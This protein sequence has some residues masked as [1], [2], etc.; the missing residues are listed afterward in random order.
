MI[1]A[2]LIDDEPLARSL[3]AEYCG[4]HPDISIV[5]ECGDGFEGLKAIQEHEPDLIFLDVQMPKISGFE[6]LELLEKK[7]GVI[8]STAF[9]EYAIKAFEANAIDY[10]LKPFSQDRF[11]KAI[12]KW[13][14]WNSLN[15]ENDDQSNKQMLEDIFQP[16]QK[17]RVVI[18]QGSTIKIIPVHEIIYLESADDFVK[19]HTSG[20]VYLKNKTMSYFEK[21]LPSSEFVRTHRSFIIQINQ[22]TRIDPY[23]KDNFVAI[24]KNGEKVSVS[25]SGYPRLR[26]A[27]G[28]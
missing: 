13:K 9:D 26:A 8:F 6:L 15:D 20:G 10:L 16:A 28:L 14:K 2:I 22:I 1:K 12:E 23:E 4:S 3:V 18:K 17:E 27:L 24:L 11:D 25:R 7:P 21:T 5:A 19:I